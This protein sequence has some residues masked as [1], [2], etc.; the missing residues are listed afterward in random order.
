MQGGCKRIIYAKHLDHLY[1]FQ[2]MQTSE[3]LLKA[4]CLQILFKSIFELEFQFHAT[5]SPRRKPFLPKQRFLT[6]PVPW[7]T[8]I[9]K[10]KSGTSL[11]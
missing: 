5:P 7:Y 11:L 8:C 3:E 9:T 1:Q 6:F 2:S 4:K 10:N